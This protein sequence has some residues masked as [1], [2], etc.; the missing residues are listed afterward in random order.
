MSFQCFKLI[1]K[2]GLCRTS[3]SKLQPYVWEGI[4]IIVE[5]VRCDGVNGFYMYIYM[6]DLR[7]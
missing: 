7:G 5:V 4:C 2:T 6:N 1:V 3:K